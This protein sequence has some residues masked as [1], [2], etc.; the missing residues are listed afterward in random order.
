MITEI[1]KKVLKK[2]VRR[3]YRFQFFNRVKA[4]IMIFNPIADP[5][6]NAD[7]YPIA[8][9]IKREKLWVRIW[10]GSAIGYGSA[11]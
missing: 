5:Y 9:P 4:L 1:R 7:P 8:D 3:G 6:P 11:M 2:C 10:M